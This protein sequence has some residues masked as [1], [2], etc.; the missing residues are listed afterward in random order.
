MPQWIV[1]EGFHLTVYAPPGLPSPEHDAIQRAL[2]DISL[3]AHL[4]RLV[5]RLFC[6]R[7]PLRLAKVRLSRCAWVLRPRVS[8]PWGEDVGPPPPAGVAR[9]DWMLLLTFCAPRAAQSSFSRQRW[10][11]GNR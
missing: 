2:N 4:L 3:Q 1:M 8:P 7:P 10:E 11:P 9:R 5:R 6:R